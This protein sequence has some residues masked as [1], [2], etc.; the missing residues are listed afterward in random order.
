MERPLISII[1]AAYNAEKYIGQMIESVLE[2]DYKEWELI[3]VDDCSTDR[4]TEIIN[5]FVDWRIKFFHTDQN[6][7]NAYIPIEIGVEYTAGDYILLLGNDDFIEE[8]YLSTVVQ[9]L[10]E[11][12]ADICTA[13]MVFVN[14][15][16]DIK[17]PLEFIPK[18]DFDL[19]QIMT[20]KEAFR[21]TFPVWEIGYNGAIIRK[22][23][24]NYA[25]KSYDMGERERTFAADENLTFLFVRKSNVVAF[26][27]AEYYYRQHNNSYTHQQFSV[28]NLSWMDSISD[29]KNMFVQDYG[30]ESEECKRWLIYD[31]RA[32]HNTLSRFL[33]S[34]AY[35][36]DKEC[37][38]CLKKLN[39]WRQRVDKPYFDVDLGK[40]R[41]SLLRNHFRLKILTWISEYNTL[42]KV[43]K[44]IL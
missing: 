6:T 10:I 23:L 37:L 21:R 8:H 39:I 32:Y 43:G 13:R 9:R 18:K 36:G 17:N 30:A 15:S 29:L 16:G 19:S 34:V 25:L 31:C 28:K 40:I 5:S 11:T 4:T 42:F 2:Q 3:I 41:Y 20:G 44:K 35:I 26:T 38:V 27:S 7:G 22:T 12:N 1:V 33:H 24:F 14:E